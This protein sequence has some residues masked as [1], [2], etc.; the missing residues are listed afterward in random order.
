MSTKKDEDET[1]QALDYDEAYAQLAARMSS[2]H[3]S[4][5]EELPRIDLYL[6]QLLSVASNELSFMLVPGETVLTGSM[7]NNYVKQRVVPAPQR[8]RYTMRSVV[9]LLFVCLFKRVLSIAQI[10]QLVD[11]VTACDIDFEKAYDACADA[12][13]SQLAALFGP[14]PGAVCAPEGAFEGAPEVKRVHLT[15]TAGQPADEGLDGLIN[16][17]ITSVANKVYVDQML[18]LRQG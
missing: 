5:S 17:A 13:E 14:K 6:D 16:A 2:L 1:T 7:V 18:A 9:C 3:I 11:L 4:R 8:K 12:L 10:H 15:D